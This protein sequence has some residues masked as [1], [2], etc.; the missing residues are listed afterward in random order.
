MVLFFRHFHKTH[1]DSR[2]VILCSMAKQRFVIRNSI[3]YFLYFYLVLIPL[4]D[5]YTVIIQHSHTFM[6]GVIN[7]AFPVFGKFPVFLANQLFSPALTKC[8][9][10]NTTN[11]N[12]LSANERF[13]QSSILS[14]FTDILRPSQS[15]SS[16]SRM[17][18][19]KASGF[20]LSNQNIRLPQHTSSIGLFCFSILLQ[21]LHF[22]NHQQCFFHD[23]RNFHYCH[24]SFPNLLL[25]SF[26]A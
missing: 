14:G 1:P 8:G 11:L 10:S 13:V 21:F 17:S 22:L 25:S 16:K 15:V 7:K 6:Y 4:E 20:C 26:K 19:N 12:V 5:K 9:G 24:S 18:V 2:P 3:D 23:Y